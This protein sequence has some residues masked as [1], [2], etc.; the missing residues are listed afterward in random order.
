MLYHFKG[1]K[2]VQNR[3]KM[4]QIL[5]LV[6]WKPSLARCVR[7]WSA[8]SAS[9]NLWIAEGAFGSEHVEDRHV[10]IKGPR[11]AITHISI[12]GLFLSVQNGLSLLNEIKSQKSLTRSLEKRQLR[13]SLLKFQN[14][15]G[16]FLFRKFSLK[17]K[18]LLN[19]ATQW[20][21]PVLCTQ[22]EIENQCKKST[23]MAFLYSTLSLWIFLSLGLSLSQY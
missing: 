10:E 23:W 9:D 22:M 13:R 14:F 7:V 8:G 12:S 17:R 5:S 1:P 20:I 15:Q 19:T 21:R 6:S 11:K 3:W 16:I 4:P 2:K 18:L